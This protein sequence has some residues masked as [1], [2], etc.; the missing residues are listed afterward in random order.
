[1]RYLLAN[2][3]CWVIP[4][5]P[6]EIHKE[7]K[8]KNSVLRTLV[9]SV[10]TFGLLVLSGPAWASSIVSGAVTGG[11]ALTAGGTFIDLTVPWGSVS[12]PANT[13]GSAN[14]VT[15]NLYAFDEVQNFTLTANLAT[16]VGLNPIPAG[17]KVNS[18]FVTLEPGATQESLIGH[19]NFNSPILAII[20]A[21]SSLRATNFLGAPGITYQDP[22]EVGLEAGQDLVT[23]DSGNPNRIDWNTLA[24]IP[25]DSVRVIT[26]SVPEPSSLLLLGTGLLGLAANVSVKRK[27]F[28][29]GSTVA[30]RSE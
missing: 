10:A 22:T 27:L 11:S 23:I 30:Q 5:P 20:T 2:G 1:M 21:D 29:K 18:S 6:R 28:C 19:V 26:E 15:P 4:P 25:G 3:L 12:S 16:E 14:F 8:L 9:F 17:T 13:V 7:D 24:S